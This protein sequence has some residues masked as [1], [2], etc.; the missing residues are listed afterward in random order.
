MLSAHPF[1]ESRRLGA[2]P[3]TPRHP[4][5]ALLDALSL[6][7]EVGRRAGGPHRPRHPPRLADRVHGIGRRVTGATGASVG[8][9]CT[10]ASPAR[11]TAASA[12]ACGPRRAGSTRAAVDRRRSAA[13]GGPARPVRQLRGQ[14]PDRRP[15]RRERPRL[16]IP[17]AVRAGG[18]DVALDRDALAAAFPDATGRVVVFLHGLCEN[19]SY[20]DRRRERGRHDVRRDA[21]RAG[22][23]AGLPARQH[24]AVAARERRRADRAAPAAGRGVAGRRSPGSRWSG[25]R[26]A[27]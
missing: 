24:R 12:R 19:E 10:A 18:R 8:E 3:S 9:A 7:A 2:W 27:G 22:L 15:P 14:R 25:T 6:L 17:M 5:P 1:T 20:W 16:A 23:D 26:W 11:C 13:R 4:A 21:G